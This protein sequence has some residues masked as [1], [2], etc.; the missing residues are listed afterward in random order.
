MEDTRVTG[1]LTKTVPVF[2]NEYFF[3]GR[4]VYTK[5]HVTEGT[6]EACYLGLGIIETNRND[7][8]ELQLTH[9]L[10]HSYHGALGLIGDPTTVIIKAEDV[11]TGTWELTPVPLT[12]EEDA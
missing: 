10:R 4:L 5:H 6:R 1:I 11:A 9:F 3:N 12:G 8:Q 2:D 7:C